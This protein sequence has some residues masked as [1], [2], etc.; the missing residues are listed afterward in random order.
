MTQ[1]P[2]KFVAQLAYRINED[3]AVVH[4]RMALPASDAHAALEAAKAR[5]REEVQL[6]KG[7]QLIAEKAEPFQQRIAVSP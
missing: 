6:S 2:T 5:F 4:F 7:A 1:S 3:D